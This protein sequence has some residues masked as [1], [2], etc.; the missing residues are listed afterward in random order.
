MLDHLLVI[1][2]PHFFPPLTHDVMS[3]LK[4]KKPTLG[5]YLSIIN[6]ISFLEKYKKKIKIKNETNQIKTNRNSC[7]LFLSLLFYLFISHPTPLFHL[8]FFSKLPPPGS[9]FHHYPHL[10]LLL[11]EIF[12][13]FWCNS[14]EL[15][16]PPI[17]S[18]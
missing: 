13:L 12:S 9:P 1:L 14:T 5:H 17:A 7:Q 16:L 6:K 8:F 18:L 15:S 3:D 2:I 4:K 11:N 10:P